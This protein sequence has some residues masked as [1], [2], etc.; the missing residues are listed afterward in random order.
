[1]NQIYY[2][3]FDLD[4][5]KWS[6]KY[7]YHLQLFLK[8]YFL[9]NY[10][11]ADKPTVDTFHKLLAVDNIDIFVSYLEQFWQIHP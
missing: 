8:L 1:M 9:L 7:Y 6:M 4:Q 3:E 2:L 10:W 5:K 11:Y